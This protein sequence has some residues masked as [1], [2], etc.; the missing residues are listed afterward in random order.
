MIES[1]LKKRFEPW[2]GERLRTILLDKIAW[3]DEARQAMKRV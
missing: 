3:R 2:C 1:M